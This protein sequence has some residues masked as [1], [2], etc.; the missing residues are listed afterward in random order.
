MSSDENLG[1]TLFKR[2]HVYIDVFRIV[3]VDKLDSTFH[4]IWEA[5]LGAG[6]IGTQ[7]RL[8]E[9]EFLGQNRDE[10]C[11]ES[12]E[13]IH[14]T[15]CRDIKG[16]GCCV[17]SVDDGTRWHREACSSKS[18]VFR[19]VWGECSDGSMRHNNGAESRSVDSE[20][21]LNVVVHSFHVCGIVARVIE[22]ILLVA[23]NCECV[24]FHLCCDFYYVGHKRDGAR[25]PRGR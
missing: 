8:G 3:N 13:S 15:L 7:Y 14:D 25:Y 4:V 22:G 18:P 12:G 10:S 5:N 2:R 6:R 11:E 1:Y 23:N 24:F 9:R 16:V 17:C 21:R 19:K 20:E